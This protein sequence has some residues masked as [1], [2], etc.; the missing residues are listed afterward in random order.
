[1]L[2][3]VDSIDASFFKLQTH[4]STIFH[5]LYKTIPFLQ[6]WSKCWHTF[7]EEL[8]ADSFQVSFK[9]ACNTVDD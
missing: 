7:G 6:L 8:L 2:H 4:K 1:M 9:V 5:A 3:S